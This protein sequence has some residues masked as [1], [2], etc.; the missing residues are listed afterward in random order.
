M[1]KK[2]SFGPKPSVVP[3]ETPKAARCHSAR[4]FSK[5]FDLE[6]DDTDEKMAFQEKYRLSI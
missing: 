1:N 2:V 3:A 4:I 6:G 5:P